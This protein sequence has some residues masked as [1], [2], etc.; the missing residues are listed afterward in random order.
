MQVEASGLAFPL[1]RFVSTLLSKQEEASGTDLF[2]QQR[3]LRTCWKTW[4]SRWPAFFEN[5]LEGRSV[6]Q[7]QPKIAKIRKISIRQKIAPTQKTRKINGFSLTDHFLKTA[8]K[9]EVQKTCGPTSPKLRKS[10]FDKKSAR[11][12]KT[13]AKSMVFRWQT[14]FLKQPASQKFQK[15]AAQNRQNC[16]K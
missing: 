15:D 12:K 10:A 9:P 6:K 8:C 3:V 2:Q 13:V 5:R 14:I 7:M 4:V 1:G 11:H 16:K